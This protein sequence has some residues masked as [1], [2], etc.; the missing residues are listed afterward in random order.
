MQRAGP[1]AYDIGS[2]DNGYTGM[3]ASHNATLLCS[4]Q[5]KGKKGQKK[6]KKKG[7]VGDWL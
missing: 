4:G 1:H 5:E 3:G 7:K 2:A 6:G